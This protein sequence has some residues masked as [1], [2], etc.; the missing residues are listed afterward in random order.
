MFKKVFKNIEFHLCDWFQSISWGLCC[1][2][3]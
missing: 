1:C 3:L 2:Q